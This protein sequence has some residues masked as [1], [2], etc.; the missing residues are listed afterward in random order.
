MVD[1][2]NTIIKPLNIPSE[3]I[4]CLRTP[5]SILPSFLT[6]LAIKINATPIV[7]NEAPK[8]INDFLL[9]DNV[10]ATATNT[11]IINPNV[12]NACHEMFSILE[13]FLNADAISAIATPIDKIINAIL[14]NCKDSFLPNL[15]AKAA[16]PPSNA[17]NAAIA[18]IE[19]HTF[20]VS[21]IVKTTIEPTKMAIDIATSFNAAVIILTLNA[22][23]TP[24][25]EDNPSAKLLKALVILITDITTPAETIPTNNE[26]K[27]KSL[28]MSI[29]LLP[30]VVINV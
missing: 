2:I 10:Q 7:A 26:P 13:I 8:L 11:P 29:I 19:A 30:T 28:T 14:P 27:S 24:L 18:P 16:N 4:P 25:I 20:P 1:A 3:I 15:P 22:F 9:L 21:N 17:I 12:V 6:T 23:K 5:L